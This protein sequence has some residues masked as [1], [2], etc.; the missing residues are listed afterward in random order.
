MSSVERMQ[1]GFPLTYLCRLSDR[2]QSVVVI[3]PCPK[4]THWKLGDTPVLSPMFLSDI[5]LFL[6]SLQPLECWATE[7]REATADTASPGLASSDLLP[8]TLVKISFISHIS[9]YFSVSLKRYYDQGN[10][11]K[12]LFTGFSVLRGLQSVIIM[13]RSMGPG[14]QALEQQLSAYP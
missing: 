13:V 7:D 4:Q 9:S 2:V 5:G 8:F 10:L 14:R 12:E 1:C 11:Q 6:C 3:Y